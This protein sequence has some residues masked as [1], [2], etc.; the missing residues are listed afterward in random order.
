MKIKEKA[1]EPV[2]SGKVDGLRRLHVRHA[3]ILGVEQMLNEPRL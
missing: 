2:Q 3:L 1:K